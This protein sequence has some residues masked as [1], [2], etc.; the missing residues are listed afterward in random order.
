VACNIACCTVLE[1][2]TRLDT[3][4][5]KL[6]AS[7]GNDLPSSHRTDQ[8]KVVAPSLIYRKRKKISVQEPLEGQNQEKKKSAIQR[9]GINEKFSFVWFHSRGLEGGFLKKTQF[10]V[11]K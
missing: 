7:S 8:N 6:G 3:A 1:L 10:P 9:N 11:L 4:A 5:T 2:E